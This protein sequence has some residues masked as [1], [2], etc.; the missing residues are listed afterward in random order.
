MNDMRDNERKEK[1]VNNTFT[2]LFSFPSPF[3]EEFPVSVPAPAVS[4]YGLPRAHTIKT[5]IRV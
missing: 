1:G 3:T 5:Q 2:L 4:Y